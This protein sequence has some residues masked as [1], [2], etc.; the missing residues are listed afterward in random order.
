MIKFTF[1]VLTGLSDV[2]AEENPKARNWGRHF[3]LPMILLIFP[4][5]LN[6]SASV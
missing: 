4:M 1:N 2:A 6:V 3:E 5:L